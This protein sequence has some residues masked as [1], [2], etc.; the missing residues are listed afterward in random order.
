MVLNLPAPFG[1]A[2]SFGV[3]PPAD[4]P[5]PAVV[6]GVVPAEVGLLEEEPPQPATARESRT[7]GT[8]I[9]P[10]TRGWR[11]S[12]SSFLGGDHPAALRVDLVVTGYGLGSLW[13]QMFSPGARASSG[14]H[15]GRQKVGARYV[16]RWRART[17]LT[18]RITKRPR[19]P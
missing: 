7:T 18:I 8:A 2:L 16:D 3:C 5:P 19:P 12:V 14:L 9:A 13:V 6:E 10:S 17:K 15:P 1:S 4:V 11:I